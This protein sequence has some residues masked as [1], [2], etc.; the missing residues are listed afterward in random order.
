[1]G[2]IRKIFEYSLA[3]VMTG[4]VIPDIKNK[5]ENIIGITKPKRSLDIKDLLG[6]D[7]EDDE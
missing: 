5:Y 2:A 6:Y 3:G 1:M 4:L 7:P